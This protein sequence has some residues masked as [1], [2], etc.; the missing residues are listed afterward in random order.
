PVEGIP[1]PIRV[2]TQPRRSTHLD[3]RQRPRQLGQQRQQGCTSAHFVGLGTALH[4]YRAH[5]LPVL[6]QP[7]AKT[8][9]AIHRPTQEPHRA[10][11]Q[12]GL[13]LVTWGQGRQQSQDRK[14]TRL[15]SS[16]VSSSYAVFCLKKI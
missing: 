10:Q 1:V 2:Q 14:S 6:H 15:N 8:L 12:V 16:H 7:R 4:H 3:Q 13:T 11:Q 5:L 9:P